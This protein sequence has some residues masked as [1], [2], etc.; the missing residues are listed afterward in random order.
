MT[1]YP[2][3]HSKDFIEAL[4]KRELVPP[5]CQRIVIDINPDVTVLYFETLADERLLKVFQD[6]SVQIQPQ[7][8]EA[9]C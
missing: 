1:K 5:N 4:V 7:D 9:E 2:I 6:P 3:K 8:E